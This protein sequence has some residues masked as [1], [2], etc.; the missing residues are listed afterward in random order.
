[1]NIIAA[2]QAV[3]ANQANRPVVGGVAVAAVGGALLCYNLANSNKLICRRRR[4]RRICAIC[5]HMRV[6]VAVAMWRP[7]RLNVS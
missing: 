6:A 3:M 1:M 7:L 4:R 2:T 5:V